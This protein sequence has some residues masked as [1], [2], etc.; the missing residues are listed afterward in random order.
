VAL[1]IGILT[2]NIGQN[3]GGI[4][5]CYALMEVLKKLN[6][7]PE[8]LYIETKYPQ[9]WKV[10]LKKY[11][12]SHFTDKYNSY[13]FEEK[14]F[15]NNFDFINKYINPRTKPL[16]SREDFEQ[17]TQ[18]D[19]D[20]YIV[21]SDQ[22]WRARMFKYIN[23]A[24]FGFVKSDK[25]ILLSYAASFGVDKWEYTEEETEKYRR[26]IQRFSG[27]SVREESGIEFC[28][29]Y[30]EKDA[31]HVLDPTM[32]HSADEYRILITNENEPNH[33]G[34][35]LNYIL[36]DTEEKLELINMISKE[37]DYKPYKINAKANSSKNVE[38]IIYPTVTS[39]LKGFDD[40]EFVITDSFHGCVF[41][42][43]FNKPFIVYGNERRGMARFE[44]LL[45]MF[46][47]DDRLVLSKDDV[48]LE[49]MNS[50]ID[51]DT[52]N[53]KLKI[54]KLVSFKYLDKILHSKHK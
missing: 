39:W 53:E 13:V 24:F 44:S 12:L 25:P 10:F 38:D 47:L 50:D 22:V 43:I 33:N 51:W 40:A 21:G 35:L 30:F 54:E 6:Y 41:S 52:V 7:E 49:M 15:K 8:L 5:Q 23:Y 32:L 20:A 17:I 18:N 9:N 1:K 16:N 11:L 27:I 2:Y 26:E 19:Y 4:L 14:I 48:S 42:I 31:L 36:D 37:L 34:K 45:K 28:S 29:K 3:Y 46:G